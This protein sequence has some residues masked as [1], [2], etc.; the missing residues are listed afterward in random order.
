MRVKPIHAQPVRPHQH[1]PQNSIPAPE[2]TVSK[3]GEVSLCNFWGHTNVI[4]F[5]D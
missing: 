3:N 5:V 4:E 2:F 1:Q